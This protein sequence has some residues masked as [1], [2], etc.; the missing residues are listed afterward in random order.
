MIRI[1][2][3][4]IL[5]AFIYPSWALLVL[6]GICGPEGLWFLSKD[7]KQ[8]PDYKEAFRSCDRY[9]NF[10]AFALAVI[11][12]IVVLFALFFSVQIDGRQTNL[13][14]T[15]I[16]GFLILIYA[17]KTVEQQKNTKYM[18]LKRRKEMDSESGKDLSDVSFFSY[19]KTNKKIAAGTIGLW[20]IFLFLFL[21][22]LVS[23][24]KPSGYRI[25]NN[26][27][28]VIMKKSVLNSKDNRDSFEQFRNIVITCSAPKIPDYTF[29]N[30]DNLESI[31]I[32]GSI[33][34]IGDSAFGLNSS[35]KQ[36]K[37]PDTVK[38]I[39]D[40]AL[41]GC[42]TLEDIYYAGSQSQWKELAKNIEIDYSQ[43]EMH[44]GG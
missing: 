7:A 41:I 18:I 2:L 30:C 29:Y 3:I 44:F 27:T 40:D 17:V 16:V 14:L 12:L 6:P 34:E 15:G 24:I 5:S 25:E 38:K 4:I 32:N 9:R 8:D 33:I 35:L 37:L 23:T 42:T 20:A 1:L 21:F 19:F 13:L 43:V 22:M 28:L 10:A 36:I 11:T 26:D 31:E 39:D